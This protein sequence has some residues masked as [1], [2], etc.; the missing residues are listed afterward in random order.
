MTQ[1]VKFIGSYLE[2]DVSFAALCHRCGISRKTGYKWRKR[3]EENGMEGLAD[4]SRAPRRH[5]NETPDEVV[6]PVLTVRREHPTWGPRKIVEYLRRRQPELAVP[7]PSTV[8][9]I[10]KRHGLVAPR[11]RKVR[12]A[13]SPSPLTDA[14][15]PN[16]VWCVDFKGEFRLKGRG[17]YCRPLTISDLHSRY[18]LTC[19]ALGSTRYTHAYPV[20]LAAFREYGL[21]SVIRSDNG[22]PFASR[23][24]GGLS[25]LSVWWIQLGIDPE[26]IAP[27]HPEQNGVHE[28]MHRNLKAEATRPA[29]KTLTAQQRRFSVWRHSYNDERPHEALDMFTPSDCYSTSSRAYPRR[30]PRPQYD[31]DAQVLTVRSQGLASFRGRT[32]YVGHNLAGHQIA[33]Q[34]V[35]DGII[36][37]RF[38]KY[39]IGKVALCKTGQLRPERE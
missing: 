31:T 22:S 1:K 20:F 39:L 29:E 36:E 30:L 10:L 23:A 9:A 37:V 25:R 35:D 16:E 34:E 18:V 14:R 26:R 2:H 6:Q 38:F 3:F 13:R 27:A 5:P 17:P 33:C 11:R 21:P 8:G 7:A 28:R 24:P 12:V 4:L 19:Q 32:L 15:A